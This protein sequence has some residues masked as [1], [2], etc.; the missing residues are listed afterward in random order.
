MDYNEPIPK[1][2][3][4]LVKEHRELESKLDRATQL[5]KAN[6]LKEAETVLNPLSSQIL[7]H[8]VEEE[9]RIIRV[10]ADNAKPE[11]ERNAEV[12]R[13]HRR[14]EEFLKDKLPRLSEFPPSTERTEILQFASE[15]KK[16]FKEEEEISFP[17][18]Q[19]LR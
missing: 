6:N 10:I 14:V 16:H 17:L 1:L 4:R 7:K 13:Y 2:V 18:A 12:M 11:L 3:E 15:L 9:A 8:A 19:K 5:A